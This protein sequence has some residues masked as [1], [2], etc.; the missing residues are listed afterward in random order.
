MSLMQ[1]LQDLAKVAQDAVTD[2]PILQ[3]TFSSTGLL[4]MGTGAVMVAVGLLVG[5]KKSVAGD[6]ASASSPL[7]TPLDPLAEQGQ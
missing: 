5:M 4:I 6:E 3:A 2:W 1:F 7:D